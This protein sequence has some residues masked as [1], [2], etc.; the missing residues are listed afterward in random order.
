MGNGAIV[1]SKKTLCSSTDLESYDFIEKM[2]LH[3]FFDH[4]ETQ[5]LKALDLAVKY[6]LMDNLELLIRSK[7]IKNTLPVHLASS[8]GSL[9]SLEILYFA[10]FS[11]GAKDHKGRLPL[12]VA[13]MTSANSSLANVTLCVSFLCV[14]GCAYVNRQDDDGNTPMHIAVIN[15]HIEAVNTLLN[16]RASLTIINNN[17]QTPRTLAKVREYD[18]LV[19]IFVR[20]NKSAPRKELKNEM[21]IKSAPIDPNRIMLVWERFFENAFKYSGAEDGTECDTSPR[22]EEK[23][24][25]NRHLPLVSAAAAVGNHA[26]DPYGRT[27]PRDGLEQEEKD[28]SEGVLEWFA[29]I[30][31]VTEAEALEDAWAYYVV[32][33]V[34]KRSEWLDVHLARQEERYGI[35]CHRELQTYCELYGFEGHELPDTV[36]RVVTYGYMSYYDSTSD[37]SIWMNLH[38]GHCEAYLPIGADPLVPYLELPSVCG[39]RAEEGEEESLWVAADSSFSYEWMIVTLPVDQYGDGDRDDVEGHDNRY[40]FLHQITGQSRWDPPTRWA[41]ALERSGGWALC[42]QYGD[43]QL[44]W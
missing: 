23:E 29:W 36:T 7:C 40:Y 26:P 35:Y 41:E 13:C 9:E 43:A 14:Y 22:M 33:K 32:N 39:A 4:H 37:S 24:D 17:G 27:S 8:H 42:Q 16:H 21:R 34:T 28:N 10:G 5:F 31:C 44:F 2:C 6:G 25:N 3:D 15:R 18:E 38:T 11:L 30:L 12:H 19:E 20:S 1:S